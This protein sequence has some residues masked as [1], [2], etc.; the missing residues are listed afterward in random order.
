MPA[1]KVARTIFFLKIVLT[2]PEK[3]WTKSIDYSAKVSNDIE[4]KP[5]DN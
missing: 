3:I 5:L 1:L 2:N 4:R